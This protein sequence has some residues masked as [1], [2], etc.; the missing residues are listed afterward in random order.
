MFVRTRE[1]SAFR[2]SIGLDWVSLEGRS[3]PFLT[4]IV[5]KNAIESTKLRGT[6]EILIE[7]RFYL[8]K[9]PVSLFFPSARYFFNEVFSEV[10]PVLTPLS[11]FPIT[12]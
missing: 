5:F 11:I 2:F 12:L 9:S 8:C 7:F 6:R 1:R 3:S 10:F 4:I